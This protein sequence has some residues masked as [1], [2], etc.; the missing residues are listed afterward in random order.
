MCNM[1]CHR[2]AGCGGG[3]GGKGLWL[4]AIPRSKFSA[5]GLFDVID[6]CIVASTIVFQRLALEEL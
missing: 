5:K 2:I 4:G 3:V 1:E 6:D